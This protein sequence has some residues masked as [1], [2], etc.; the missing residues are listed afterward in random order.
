MA[1]TLSHRHS[2]TCEVS[3]HGIRSE[4]VTSSL[5]KV[6]SRSVPWGHCGHHLKWPECLECYQ[7]PTL[8]YG[9]ECILPHTSHLQSVWAT[10]V[11]RHL[12]RPQQKNSSTVLHILMRYPPPHRKRMLVISVTFQLTVAQYPHTSQFKAT[13][14]TYKSDSGGV[15]RYVRGLSCY[16]SGPVLES[17]LERGI[18]SDQFLYL[19]LVALP[20]PQGTQTWLQ[21]HTPYQ[22]PISE[23][24]L[25]KDTPA[26]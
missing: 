1:Y 14:C 19:C 20:K 17:A 6:Q 8:L 24:Q 5:N 3:N 22:W 12:T 25:K 13:V 11:H 10:S 2:P 9:S 21:H 15:W 4:Q 18:M 16:L 26:S 7:K 23:K